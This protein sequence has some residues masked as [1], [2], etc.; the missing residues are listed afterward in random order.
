M[1]MVATSSVKLLVDNEEIKLRDVYFVPGVTKSIL[2]IGQIVDQG[3]SLLFDHAQ[4][5]VY[6][7][8]KLVGKGLRDPTSSLYC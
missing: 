3:Y 8:T 4:C 5:F 1:P 7:G 2:S 6:D